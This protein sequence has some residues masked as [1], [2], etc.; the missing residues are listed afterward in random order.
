MDLKGKEYYIFYTGFS[1][2]YWPA[3]YLSVLG[4]WTYFPLISVSIATLGLSTLFKIATDAN[5]K[6]TVLV[7]KKLPIQGTLITS[8]LIIILNLLNYH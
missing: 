4:V 7:F 5:W 8:K 6:K 1:V 3:L 2:A